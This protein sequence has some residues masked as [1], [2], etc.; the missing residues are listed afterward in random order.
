[1]SPIRYNFSWKEQYLPNKQRTQVN[2]QTRAI[3]LIIVF[4]VIALLSF[5]LF[6]KI[7]YIQ[8][9][10]IKTNGLLNKISVEKILLKQL[11]ERRWYVFKQDHIIFLDTNRVKELINQQIITEAITISYDWHGTLT[12]NFNEKPVAFIVKNFDKYFGIDSEGV[13]TKEM[14]G[15]K[16]PPNSTIIETNYSNISMKSKV[17]DSEKISLLFTNDLYKKFNKVVLDVNQP[18]T[19][20]FYNSDGGEVLM[21]INDQYLNQFKRLQEFLNKKQLNKYQKVDLRFNDKIYYQ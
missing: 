16:L 21:N 17:L 7:W 11:Q 8:N 6:S 2:K 18:Q 19:I 1:M 4:I 20:I 14:D 5:F 9:I 12:L 10:L 3:T 15:S 13:I